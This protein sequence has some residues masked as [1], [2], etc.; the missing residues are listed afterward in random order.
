[1]DGAAITSP[2]LGGRRRAAQAADEPRKGVIDTSPI[3][4]TH[5]LQLRERALQA[6]LDGQGQG[7][8][9]LVRAGQY[10]QLELEGEGAV[11]RVSANSMTSAQRN[12]E[13][14]AR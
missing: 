10:V 4:T 3:L 9:S 2:C 5:Q 12:P 8:R 14:I 11:W 6:K 13:P 7:Q 1:V